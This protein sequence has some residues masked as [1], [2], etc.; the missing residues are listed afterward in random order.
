MASG[1]PRGGVSGHAL[2]HTPM[3]SSPSPVRR[4]AVAARAAANPVEEYARTLACV[5]R[6]RRRVTKPE[7]GMVFTHHHR[8]AE[9]WGTLGHAMISAGFRVLD[10]FPVRSEG[11]SGFHSYGGSIKWDSV[12]GCRRGPMPRYRETTGQ[13]IS[14]AVCSA[15]ATA[16]EWADRL[17]RAERRRFYPEG[18]ETASLLR[19]A[20]T[21]LRIK[22]R[23]TEPLRG[24]LRPMEIQSPRLPS[25]R[26]ER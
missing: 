24:G 11:Q 21:A 4:S 18:R 1:D 12:M 26:L 9:A 16:G 14:A 6:K 25:P 7:A 20:S 8:S 23:W 10:V 15:A 19:A 5:F 22:S 17:A 2:E 13:E 3:G